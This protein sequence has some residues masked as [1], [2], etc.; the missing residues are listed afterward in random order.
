[1]RN[2]LI[3][4]IVPIYN[5]QQ[6]LQRCITSLVA[7]SYKN[8]EIILVDDG[9]HDN[10]LKI[11]ETNAFIDKR[12][13]VVCK[14]NGGAA[15]ARNKGIEV[16]QGEYIVFVDSDDWIY[17]NAIEV[18]Y[19]G[20]KSTQSDLTT[21][22]VLAKNIREHKYSLA[23]KS[24]DLKKN[25]KE[26]KIFDYLK[27]LCSFLPVGKIYKNSIIKGNNIFFTPHM[28]I[29]E[30][31]VFV[32]TYLKY[33]SKISTLHDIVYFYDKTNEQSATHKF[34]PQINEWGAKILY[35]EEEFLDCIRINEKKKSYYLNERAKSILKSYCKIYVQELEK[36]QAINKIGETCK[37]FHSWLHKSSNR[38]N[39]YYERLYRKTR[40]ALYLKKPKEMIKKIFFRLK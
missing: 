2:E 14:E 19:I 24:I 6:Y 27:N 21:A 1:M 22:G 5:S 31:T 18:L 40:H 30:D 34:Y 38:N 16:S 37:L 23:T 11:C 36:K 29:G 35:S 3:S 33:C 9:S 8:I 32:R 28:K 25:V 13:K 10:S 12:I 26:K 7:Q 17:Q 15:S 4:I 20:L 39:N